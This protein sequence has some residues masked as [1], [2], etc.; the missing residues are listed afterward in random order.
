MDGCGWVD[1]CVSDRRRPAQ[2]PTVT[3]TGEDFGGWSLADLAWTVGGR[4]LSLVGGQLNKGNAGQVR[5]LEN[6]GD[7]LQRSEAG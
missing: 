6:S 3:E 4:R 5:N 1:G 7:R 2:E